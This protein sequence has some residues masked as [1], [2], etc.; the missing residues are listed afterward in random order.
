[1]SEQ[2]PP[3]IGKL[4][5]QLRKR[6]GLTQDEVAGR[7]PEGLA[8]E[9]IRNIER[10]RTWPRRHSLDQLVTALSLDAAEREAVRA[11]WLAPAGPRSGAGA[12]SSPPGSY[13][14]A[15]PA[16]RPLVGREHAEAAVMGLLARDWTRLLTLTGPGGVGKTSLGLM[17]AERVRPSYRDGVVFVDLAPLS[18]AELVTAYIARSVGVGEQ[19]TRPLTATV[20]DCLFDRRLLLFLDNFEQV[21]DAAQVVAELCAACPALQVLVTSRMALQLR[22]EQVYPVA[23][24]PGPPAGEMLGLDALAR[25]PSVA[26]LVQQA[27]TRRPDFALS[28]ANAAAVAGLCERLDGLPLAIELAAARLPVMSPAALLTR[29][30]ASLG[31][32]GEGPRDVP[33]R[34]RTM[35]D[36]IA[37]SYGLLAE[38]HKV[39]FRRLAVFAGRCT[40]AAASEV[41]A[42]EGGAGAKTVGSASQS[43]P[44][45]LDGLSALV[46]SQLLEVMD[47]GGPVGAGFL[48][49]EQGP[50]PNGLRGEEAAAPSGP[51]AVMAPDAWVGTEIC[52][53]QLETVRAYALEQLEGSAE[54][55]EVHRRHALYYLSQAQ[56]VNRALGGP[57]E[58]AWLDVTE[59]EH[60]NLRAAL[61]WARDDGQVALGLEMSGALWVFWQR[62]GHLS[63]GRRWLELFL[64][65]PS[66]EQ[67]P[68]EVRAEALTGAAWLADGQDDFG[69]A[70]ALF[71]QA[72]PLYHALGQ[73]GRVAGVMAHRARMARDR[74]RYDDAIRLVET[75]LELARGSEDLAEIANDTFG[76]GLVMQ[77]R[78]ELDQAQAAYEESLERYR[79]LGV[80]DRVA[81]ALLGLGAVSRD[82]GDFSML[83]AYC[84][85]SLEMSRELGIPWGTGY[86][87]NSLALAAAIRGDFDRARELLT[88]AL[89]LFGR[90]G[91]RVGV[92]E[93]LL[94][95]GQVEADHGH[96]AA[97][98]PLLQESL[99][100]VWPAG[101][102]HMVATSLEEVARVMV[103]EGDARKSA[104]LSAAALAWRGRMG[105]PVPP[106]RWAQVD[107]TVA[108]A[109]QAL[110][111]EAFATA[112]KDGQELPPD[113]AVLLA[114]GPMAR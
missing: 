3:D 13:P 23:P 20:V 94:F 105:A 57:R 63:E 95:S 55:P 86:S 27:R 112:W 106:S 89:E 67:A 75:S 52:F 41:C 9:T 92:A 26:L 109:R 72:L 102:H 61:G 110:G 114:L 82:K 7:A 71:D 8:V 70:E 108:A 77:E 73:T 19:G 22:D 54:A 34:H 37:W 35:R 76:L 59:A 31:A 12:A 99:R 10:G 17:V 30:E 32:L 65:A 28:D 53:R 93:A 107:F 25:V 45:L 87:L 101:P 14:G 98:L 88:E 83:E 33:A 111:E 78:G 100:Q 84:S 69:A 21:L 48:G 18:S 46:E 2:V 6:R 11:A 42:L 62:R 91:V 51:G 38:E 29:L 74:G 40:L 96:A 47:T 66:A 15:A 85:Q 49:G 80:R 1:M 103:V 90:Q 104:V 56:A 58:Q 39:L 43:S 44:D 36:V 16:A 24:L 81:Y 64:G 68:S 97:A 79:A 4:L 50:A 5:Q 60:A 113:H